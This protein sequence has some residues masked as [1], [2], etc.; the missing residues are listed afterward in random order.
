[1]FSFDVV[2]QPVEGMSGLLGRD[3]TKPLQGNKFRKFRNLILNIDDDGDDS[4][5]EYVD[6][7]PFDK[8]LVSVKDKFEGG[9]MGTDGS[10]YCMPLR[11]RRCVR[12]VPCKSL[13]ASNA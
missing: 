10:I 12:V 11:A 6:V 4:Y 2:Q 13:L 3:V 5:D 8:D 7:L 1:M 9:V